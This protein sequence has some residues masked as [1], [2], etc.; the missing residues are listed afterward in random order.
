ML[1]E[2]LFDILC[3]LGEGEGSHWFGAIKDI[4]NV[5]GS[6]EDGVERL[7]PLSSTVNF[8]FFIAHI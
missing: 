3:F 4:N 6:A 2:F 7:A 8:F 1:R 5:E